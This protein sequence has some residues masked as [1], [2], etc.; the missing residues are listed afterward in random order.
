MATFALQ[1]NMTIHSVP[2]QYWDRPKDSKSKIHAI[3]DGVRILHAIWKM[4]WRGKL[5]NQ[6][7]QK[8]TGVF[9][10]NTPTNRP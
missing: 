2:I 4:Y 1:H 6:K 8:E 5:K 7:K 9:P 10:G 3:K